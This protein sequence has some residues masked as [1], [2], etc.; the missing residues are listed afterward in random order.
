M[1]AIVCNLSP[2]GVGLFM[3]QDDTAT[4]DLLGRAILKDWRAQVEI[5]GLRAFQADL[6]WFGPCLGGGLGLGFR[7]SEE[8]PGLDELAGEADPMSVLEAWSEVRAL[9]P[10]RGTGAPDDPE[11]MRS[12]FE[13]APIGLFRVSPEGKVVAANPALA[14]LLGY[15][16]PAA[17]IGRSTSVFYDDRALM[18]PMEQWIRKDGA[19]HDTSMEVRRADGSTV[20]VRVDG[21]RVFDRRG[22]L[23]GLQG[24]VEDA[25]EEREQARRLAEA[26]RKAQES[27]ELK[28]AFL[29][30]L[31]HEVRTPLNVLMGFAELIEDELPK[32]RGSMLE[33]ASRGLRSSSRRLL[34]TMQG[35]VDMAQIQSGQLV[36]RPAWVDLGV[37][38]TERVYEMVA[39]AQEK[40]LSLVHVPGEALRVEADAECIGKALRQLLDNAIKF[41]ERGG[42]RVRAYRDEDRGE[43]AIE[44]RD[45]GVGISKEFFE[46]LFAPFRQE[47]SGLTRPYEGMGVGLALVKAY[48]E[49]SR[50]RVSVESTFGEGS[51]FTIHLPAPPS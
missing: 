19:V 23:I 29:M 21:R 6:R 15:G 48:V 49:L 30:N 40:G 33:D 44:V 31:S 50:G 14:R 3:D 22:R 27:D 2:H 32:G 11:L 17:L 26:L 41:T 16:D 36:I 45:T 7:T 47:R 37:I 51:V 9:A 10:S 25:T 28:T 42:V 8:V 18:E 5:A 35:I 38:I 4:A 20:W 39:D 12:F 1:A 46:K 43:C 24:S 34:N 13:E